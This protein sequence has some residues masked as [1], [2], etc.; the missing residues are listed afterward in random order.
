MAVPPCAAM[1]VN[2]TTVATGITLA[3]LGGL[4][5]VAM[6]A[7][8]KTTS[9]QPAAAPAAEVRTETVHRTVRVHRKQRSRPTPS[10]AA[11]APR[12]AAPAPRAYEDDDHSG[13]GRGGHHGGHG[14]GGDD[15]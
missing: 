9:Q 8:G 4:T 6:S 13:H 1:P 7:G 2:R 12:P 10:V 11:P 5:A 3:A 15:D 14:H